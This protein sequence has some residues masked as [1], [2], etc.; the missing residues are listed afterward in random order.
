MNDDPRHLVALEQC[1]LEL[2]APHLRTT[3][4]RRIETS[5]VDAGSLPDDSLRFVGWAPEAI[6]ARFPGLDPSAAY[7]LEA[8]CICERHVRRV[9]A[10][11]SRGRGAAPADRARAGDRDDRP[12]RG[13][14]G[15]VCGRDARRGHRA[16]RWA[17]R[18][19][20]RAAAVLIPAAGSRD[21]GR[22]RLARRAHR[23]GRGAGRVGRG[24]GAGARDRRRG[25]DRR[26]DR[27]RGPVPR[28]AARAPAARPTRARHDRDGRCAD[29]RAGRRGHAP[30]L[31]RPARAAA[32]DRPP[33]P[34]RRLDLPP[35]ALRRP[36][37]RRRRVDGARPRPRDLRRP[38]SRG[39][40]RD[41]PAHGR[42]AFDVDRPRGLPSLRRRVRPGRGGR[43]RHAR[44]R[45]RQRRDIVR[46]RAD[47]VP[48]PRPS[49]TWRSR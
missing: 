5:D 27:C 26:V 13:A 46:R 3:M 10:M 22:R 11:T 34:G 1:G 7:A 18:R 29:G 16:G 35:R 36:W 23:H 48:P 12:G 24:R 14:A 37:R 43:Q 4:K 25:H 38:G 40:R 30:R 20:V 15:G 49:T 42:A 2:Q 9:V 19:A 33:G 8:T 44:G 41:A 39:R 47:P 17:G 31:A 28:P 6:E 45:A 32:R 21:H